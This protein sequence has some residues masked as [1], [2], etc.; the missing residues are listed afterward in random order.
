MYV[1][2]ITHLSLQFTP[3]QLSPPCGPQ[4]SFNELQIHGCGFWDS[5]SIVVTFTSAP[6]DVL[7]AYAAV[8]PKPRSCQGEFM[9]KEVCECISGQ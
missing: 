3:C 9:I 1:L 6:K 5:D 4:K 8:I 2:F 7:D